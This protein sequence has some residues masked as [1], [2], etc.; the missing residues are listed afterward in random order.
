MSEI[1]VQLEPMGLP[2]VEKCV[3]CGV[4]TRY[5]HVPSNRPCCRNC[6]AHHTLKRL[7]ER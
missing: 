6:A 7:E 3:L 4:P 2:H 5:W 1:E